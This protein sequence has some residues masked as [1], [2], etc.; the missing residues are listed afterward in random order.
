MVETII[1]RFET[2]QRIED[3]FFMAELTITAPGLV[4][5]LPTAETVLSKYLPEIELSCSKQLESY[6]WRIPGDLT[7]SCDGVQVGNN[8]LILFTKSKGP[9]TQ[10][11]GLQQLEDQ[12][13][14]TKSEAEAGCK[15]VAEALH[16]ESGKANCASIAIDNAAVTMAD[17]L[18]MMVSNQCAQNDAKKVCPPIIVSR[19]LAHCLDLGPKDLVTE[20]NFVNPVLSKK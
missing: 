20:K 4:K 18:R 3:T 7:V 12:V 17:E 5:L 16:L 1:S 6:S 11:L 8:N 13:H 2:P 15:I 9:V 14:V 19:D 10:F